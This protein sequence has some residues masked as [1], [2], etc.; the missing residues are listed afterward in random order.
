MKKNYLANGGNDKVG[1]V[2]VTA[3]IP[4]LF[5]DDGQQR[6]AFTRDELHRALAQGKGSDIGFIIAALDRIYGEDQI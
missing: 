4:L 3:M 2:G 6:L 5:S 1:S